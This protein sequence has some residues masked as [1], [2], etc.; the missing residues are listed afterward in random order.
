MK[1]RKS[2]GWRNQMV[3]EIQGLV[4][5]NTSLIPLPFLTSSRGTSARF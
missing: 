5:P 1:W 3:T 4:I 2:V